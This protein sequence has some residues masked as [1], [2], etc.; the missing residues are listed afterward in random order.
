MGIPRIPDHGVLLVFLNGVKLS[1]NDDFAIEGRFISV[2]FRIE[3]EDK[4]TFISLSP[5]ETIEF[6]VKLPYRYDAWAWFDPANPHDP[7]VKQIDAPA[8]RVTQL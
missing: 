4:L 5:A 6:E 3:K 8:A 7:K 2:G 1:A